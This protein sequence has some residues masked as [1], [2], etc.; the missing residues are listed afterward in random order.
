MKIPDDV[1]LRLERAIRELLAAGWNTHA[2]RD[3]LAKE[4]SFGKYDGCTP[5]AILEI[6]NKICAE[7]NR[8]QRRVYREAMNQIASDQDLAGMR[9]EFKKAEQR[10]FGL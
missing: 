10:A 2:V 5:L 9:R 7:F 1:L 3:A 6:A 4:Q 8:A